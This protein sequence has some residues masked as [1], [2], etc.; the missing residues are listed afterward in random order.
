MNRKHLYSAYTLLVLAILGFVLL[1]PFPFNNRYTCIYHRMQDNV[2]T[3][4]PAGHHATSEHGHGVPELLDAYLDRFAFF[5]WG[6][7][8]LAIFAFYDLKKQLYKE[9]SHGGNK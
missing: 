2:A 8:A 5:W 1:F 7:I 9:H 3:F 4:E 6:F